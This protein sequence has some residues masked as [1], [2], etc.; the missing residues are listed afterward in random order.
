MSGFDNIILLKE[1]LVPSVEKDK[2]YILFEN[3]P[4][5]VLPFDKDFSGCKISDNQYGVVQSG[6]KVYMK[7]LDIEDKVGYPVDFISLETGLL[8]PGALI[9]EDLFKKPNGISWVIWLSIYLRNEGIIVR[10]MGKQSEPKKTFEQVKGGQ[11]KHS[12]SC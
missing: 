11:E 10:T 6:F 2:M 9:K 12:K 3:E 7:K 8:L 4:E 5:N 1:N